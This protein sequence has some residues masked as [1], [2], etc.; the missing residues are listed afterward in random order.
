M[1]RLAL[2]HL[3]VIEAIGRTENVSASARELGLTQSAVSHR[4]KEAERRVG[5]ALFRKDG[6]RMTLTQS[7]RRLFQAAERILGEV[8]QAERDLERLSSGFQ[9]TIRIGAACYLTFDWAPKMFRA[10]REILPEIEVEISTAISENPASLLLDNMAD[11]VLAAGRVDIPGIMNIPLSDDELVAV[12]PENH[13]AAGK[14]W[15]DPL[16]VV[17]QPYVTHHTIPESGREYENIFKPHSVIPKEVICAGRT[18]AVLELVENGFGMTIL[19]KR[20]VEKQVRERKLVTKSVTRAGVSITW[21]ALTRERS[22]HWSSLD[23]VLKIIKQV[24]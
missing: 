20:S 12:L 1:I 23:Q 2:H 5:A 10:L 19:P 17:D 22:E 3:A 7:G 6:H 15:F 9:E 14:D 21:H 4:M 13:M 18:L 11:M 16:E 24:L 8:G